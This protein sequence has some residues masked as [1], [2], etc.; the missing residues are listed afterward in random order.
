MP[1]VGGGGRTALSA[2]AGH[3]AGRRRADANGRG[4][5][6]PAVFPYRLPA[7]GGQRPA[8]YV[9]HQLPGPGPGAAAPGAGGALPSAGLTGRRD[10]VW[11]QLYGAF[12]AV[13]AIFWYAD[14]ERGYESNEQREAG[15]AHSRPAPGAGP[16]P[17]G[18]GPPPGGHRQGGE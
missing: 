4:A 17:A 16:D 12:L 18:T 2:G 14:Q 11:A 5:G 3:P 10:L 8:P 9:G 6:D 1:G 13:G 7:L 15:G